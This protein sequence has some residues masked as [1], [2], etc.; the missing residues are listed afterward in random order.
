MKRAGNMLVLY[1]VSSSD[2]FAVLRCDKFLPT[3]LKGLTGEWS[4]FFGTL[5][6]SSNTIRDLEDSIA[7]L[8][9][10]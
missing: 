2:D 1:C 10:F 6:M 3:L 5:S 9:F 4:F 7:L 8:C